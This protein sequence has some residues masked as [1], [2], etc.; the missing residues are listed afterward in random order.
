MAVVSAAAALCLLA[1]IFPASIGATPATAQAAA[2]AFSPVRLGQVD[3]I[4]VARG[5]VIIKAE[6]STP[7]APPRRD[8]VSYTMQPGDTFANVAGQ[9]GLTLNTLL[10]ANHIGDVTAARRGL[11]LIIPPVNGVL[12]RVTAGMSLAS[13]SQRYSVDPQ[14]VID[15]NYIRDADHLQPGSLLMLPDGKGPP[16]LQPG[17]RALPGW[18]PAFSVRPD[19]IVYVGSVTGSGGH[20]PYGQCTWWV[21]HKRYV[22]WNGD[23]WMWWANA[24]AFGFPEGQTPAPGAIMVAGISAWSPWG[25]VA[26]VESVNRDGSFVVSEMNYGRW[27][28]VDYR[29]IRSLGGQDILGFIY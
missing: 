18:S 8:I 22:P 23:A 25:H 11:K 3:R 9:F 26:Y 10:W 20:F 2:A 5:G 17:R 24:R 15:F 4:P 21:A 27:G 28:V 16:L 12:V 7:N 14:G 29:T 19:S 1:G 6:I 13:L